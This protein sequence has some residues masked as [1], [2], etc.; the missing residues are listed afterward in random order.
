[1]SIL[2]A[3]SF[4]DAARALVDFWKAKDS[5]KARVI[6]MLRF[7]YL[8]VLQN[9]SVLEM[10]A[11]GEGKG[12][13]AG[14]QAWLLVAR[15][16]STAAHEAAILSFNPAMLGE[17][18]LTKWR[19]LSFLGTDQ[20]PI[21]FEDD[22]ISAPNESERAETTDLDNPRNVLN[23]LRF[24]HSKVQSLKQLA[25][26][27]PACIPL[28]RNCRFSVRLLNIR[29]CEERLR[30]VLRAHLVEFSRADAKLK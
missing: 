9:L 16:L 24:I 3:A 26:A 30:K 12:Q 27:D 2:T 20:E 6:S 29:A 23:C 19:L 5:E 22:G 28:R 21:I 10:Y 17:K 15:Q 8:E 14:D 1:M 13:G 18:A 25:S 11:L 4:I 7:L